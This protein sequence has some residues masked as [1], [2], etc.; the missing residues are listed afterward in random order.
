MEKAINLRTEL[1]ENEELCNV[2]F[3]LGSTQKIIKCH[4]LIMSINSDYFKSVFY[5]DNWEKSKYQI[6]KITIPDLEPS[7]FQIIKKYLY[8]GILDR[9]VNNC[10]PVLI[11]GSA[12]KI[13]PLV[14]KMTKFILKNITDE[15]CLFFL[16]FSLHLQKQEPIT[17]EVT[18]YLIGNCKGVFQ[19]E[20]CL[21][22]IDNKILN[23]L[24]HTASNNYKDLLESRIVEKANYFCKKSKIKICNSN[25]IKF[26]KKLKININSQ[27]LFNTQPKA[28]SKPKKRL[29]PDETLRI[30]KKSQNFQQMQSKPWGV[31]EENIPTHQINSQ[32]DF[33]IL[34]NYK[35]EKHKRTIYNNKTVKQFLEIENSHVIE[36]GKKLETF[37]KSKNEKWKIKGGNQE[38]ETEKEIEIEKDREIENEKETERKPRNHFYTPCSEEKGRT[39]TKTGYPKKNSR[40][41]KTK[42]KPLIIEKF[43]PFA[44]TQNPLW[45]DKIQISRLENLKKDLFNYNTPIR[46]RKRKR[47]RL[48]SKNCQKIPHLDFKI[49]LMTTD[50]DK[51][52]HRDIQS[53]ILSG[54]PKAQFTTLNVSRHTPSINVLGGYDCI[55]LYSLAETFDDPTQMGNLLAQYVED[56]GG[57]VVCSCRSLTLHTSQCRGDGLKGRIV[58]QHFLPVTKAELITNVPGCLGQITD[59][60]HPLVLGV[61]EF[62]GGSLPYRTN[63]QLNTK[64]DFVQL[65]QIA[66]W[67]D[68]LP[69]IAHKRLN[70]EFGIVVVLNMAPVLGHLDLQKRATRDSS[71]PSEDGKRIISNSIKYAGFN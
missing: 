61:K 71:L 19:I 47:K 16:Q 7:I 41:Q 39:A 67:N 30:S 59:K 14:D 3:V 9:N 46:I 29:H 69:L 18:R 21:N 11:S 35:S 63:C 36:C 62:R 57:L 23:I 15:N 25:V 4:K 44:F 6:V 64:G 22:L 48:L 66:K 43:S 33:P 28:T 20:N 17:G 45:Q 60:S 52:N 1:Y 32:K 70:Q 24:Y 34:V 10:F 58:D 50:P 42:K 55:F 49:L 37:K 12:F 51:R 65:K 13:S 5:S 8:L 26:F 54:N 27:I 40:Y 31:P 56:G 38:T 2:E 68:S 53:S